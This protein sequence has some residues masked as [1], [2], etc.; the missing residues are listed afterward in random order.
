MDSKKKDSTS[1]QEHKV[2][3]SKTSL[4]ITLSLF[5]IVSL[6][7]TVNGTRI[8]LGH[9]D[10]LGI[11]SFKLPAYLFFEPTLSLKCQVNLEWLQC[12]AI[13]NLI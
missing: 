13:V 8:L 4:F 5:Q 1:F 7:T 11:G 12:L 3:I 10:P 9:L 6:T 2:C